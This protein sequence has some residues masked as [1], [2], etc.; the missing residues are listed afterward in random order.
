[1]LSQV[2]DF[3]P[4][5]AQHVH[6]RGRLGAAPAE[7][8]DPSGLGGVARQHHQANKNNPDPDQWVGYGDRTVDEMGH[9]WLNI[10]YYTDE[11]FKEELAKRAALIRRGVAAVSRQHGCHRRSGGVR[12]GG[13]RARPYAGARPGERPVADFRCRRRSANT[14]RASRRR[15]RK[16]G[17][18]GKDGFDYASSGT[19]TGTPRRNSD[20]PIGPNNRVDPVASTRASRRTFCSG[21][22]WGVFTVKMGAKGSTSVKGREGDIVTLVS[23]RAD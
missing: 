21:R 2:T 3:N 22:Q 8:D 10:T 5:L 18:H 11:E 14:A 20:V 19:S 4:Q 15:S 12:C 17:T 1:M 13:R 16:L 9:A 6:L 7:G 23:Q